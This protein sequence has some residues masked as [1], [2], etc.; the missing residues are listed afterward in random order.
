[1]RSLSIFAFLISVAAL[2]HAETCDLLIRGGRVVDGTG[3]P[4]RFVDV[5]VKDGRIV[6]IGKLAGGATATLEVQGLIVA[7]GF[8][9]VHTHAEDIAELPLAENF[10]RMG[11]TTLV[12][13]NCGGS[14]L[15]VG[16][17]FKKLEA[18]GISPNVATL[19]GHNTVRSQV[20]CGA[21]MRPPTGE[22]LTRMKELV[23]Q[24]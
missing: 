15:N 10:L 2:A 4:A 9:D 22:E 6:A 23:E 8:I 24:G 12:L 13:G 14:T 17:F 3:S 5:A 7:P 16:E 1:M 19:I 11:V 18:L 21:F 20:M